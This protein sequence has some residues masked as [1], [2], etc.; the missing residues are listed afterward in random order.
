MP[1]VSVQKIAEIGKGD[2]N[3]GWSQFSDWS[4]ED[5]FMSDGK[6]ERKTPKA[7]KMP[8]LKK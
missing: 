8:K 5:Y 3:N 4:G 7:P 6:K 1:K 2:K